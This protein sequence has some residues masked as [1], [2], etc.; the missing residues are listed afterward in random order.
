MT[1]TAAVIGYGTSFSIYG[2]STYTAVAEVTNITWPGYTRDAVDATN[3]AS[4]NEFRE[5]IPGLM[6][7][8]EVTIEMNYI[9]SA[10]DVIIAALTAAT[11]GQFKIAA[12]SGVN[13]VF[14]AI[15]TA[16]S[17]QAPLEDK[18]SASATFKITGKPVWA[19]S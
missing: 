16:Y 13:I 7:A 5:F 2:G 15:V 19:A 3:M 4:P 1:A 18:M 9:P 14:N 6:D 8:G 12:A 17:P 10:S 11:A